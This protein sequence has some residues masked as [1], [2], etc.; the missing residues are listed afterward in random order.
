MK[1][2]VIEYYVPYESSDI[3]RVFDSEEKAQQ[4]VKDNPITGSVIA[5]W[6]I[7]EHWVE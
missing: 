4:W 2:Y 3:E 5:E 7:S 6:L 1:V